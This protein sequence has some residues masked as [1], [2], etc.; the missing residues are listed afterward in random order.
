MAQQPFM[1]L[2]AKNA[3]K[4]R[5]A[6]TKRIATPFSNYQASQYAKGKIITEKSGFS[7]FD[8]PRSAYTSPLAKMQGFQTIFGETAGGNKYAKAIQ[9]PSGRQT[10]INP[11][12]HLKQRAEV[13]HVK[14]AGSPLG[15]GRGT[16]QGVFVGGR[17]VTPEDDFNPFSGETRKPVDVDAFTTK[18]NT[19][20]D[21]YN[22]DLAPVI[23]EFNEKRFRLAKQK[24]RALN[25]F[26]SKDPARLHKTAR[27]ETT[28]ISGRSKSKIN[29]KAR[30]GSKGSS[31]GV[32]LGTGG[33]G[34]GI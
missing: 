25:K 2:L 13:R 11:E 28:N 3:A 8:S 24:N 34:I 12:A 20:A 33:S 1:S 27:Q 19:D 9:G 7:F 21:A 23:A 5:Q 15:A 30:I 32:G 26:G 4:R 17:E 31:R 14:V 29:S 16:R 18:Y 10:L 6:L 22:A